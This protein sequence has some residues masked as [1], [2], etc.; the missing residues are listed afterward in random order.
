MPFYTGIT[1][2]DEVVSTDQ[3]NAPISGATFDTV[4]FR[5]GATYALAV[6]LSLVD[7]ARAVFMAS[8][9][10]TDYGKYQLYVNNITTNTIYTSDV[11]DVVSASTTAFSTNVYVG[12]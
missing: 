8:F 3:N 6:T 9:T 7:E 4:L 11:F 5:N 2:Y 1:I 10:P 12:L